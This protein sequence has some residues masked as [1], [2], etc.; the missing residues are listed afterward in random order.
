MGRER[1]SVSSFSPTLT[2]RGTRGP[3]CNQVIARDIESDFLNSPSPTPPSEASKQNG[4]T[5]SEQRKSRALAHECSETPP[6]VVHVAWAHAI[7]SQPLH[8]LFSSTHE[9]V[10]KD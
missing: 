10:H 1:H 2:R 7:F 3:V 4:T 8:K 9:A 6:L 5:T